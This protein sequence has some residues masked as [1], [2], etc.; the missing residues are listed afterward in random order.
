M[1]A[2]VIHESGGPEVLKLEDLPIPIA[3]TGE[4][5][6]R[7]RAFGL[8]RSELFTRQGHSPSV[9][10]PRILGIEAVGEVVAA[11]GTELKEGTAV[12]TTMGG[13]GRQFNGSYAEFTCVPASQVKVLPSNCL[14]WEALGALPEMLQTAWGSLFSA[15][16]LKPDERLL[17]RGGTTSIGLM[18]AA[19]A[20]KHGAFVAVTTR[21]PGR[22]TMLQENGADLVF[23]DDGAVAGQIKQQGLQLFNKVLELV[24]TGTLTDSLR[25]AAWQGSVCMTGMVG[26]EWTFEKFSPMDIVPHTVNLTIYS[27]GVEDFMATPY[28]ELIPQVEAGILK[29][30]LGKTFHL[31]EIVEAHRCLEAGSAGGKIVILTT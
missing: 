12:A 5:L 31:Q 28:E 13:M 24:G 15:L 30:R 8:N 20:K 26:N 14:T 27:G 16:R 3:K 6:I 18:A 9:E 10:F 19:I 4:V 23:I 21:Q 25:C 7:V 29:V 17:I 1:K 11:P 22:V 2:A